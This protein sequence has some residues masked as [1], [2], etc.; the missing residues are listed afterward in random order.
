MPQIHRKQFG[1]F[2]ITNKTENNVP[3]CTCDGIPNILIKNL[4][5]TKAIY[6]AGIHAFCILPN[7]IHLILTTSH[8][9]LSRFMQ[10]FKSNSAKE[11]RAMSSRYASRFRWQSGFY[12]EWIRD[13]RQLSAA[14]AYV[15]GNGM[16][17]GLA[18]EIE[19]WPWSSLHYQE[20]MDPLDI[21]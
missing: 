20:L 15:Q 21:W 13:E 14:I 19:E 10:S 17:H 18:R 7:H 16:K 3:W 12:D 5:E 1:L 6:K 9:G 2:H 11:I 4:F 8:R